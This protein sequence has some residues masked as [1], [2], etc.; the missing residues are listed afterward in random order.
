MKAYK[1][2][3]DHKEKLE[4]KTVVVLATD[5]DGLKLQIAI[6]FPEYDWFAPVDEVYDVV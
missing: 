3:L 1:V 5:S 2:I 6:Q 4:R